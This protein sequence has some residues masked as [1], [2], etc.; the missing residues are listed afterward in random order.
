METD[1][2]GAIFSSSLGV[3]PSD[4]VSRP[5]EQCIGQIVVPGMILGISTS[6]MS[7]TWHFGTGLAQVPARSPSTNKVCVLVR[8]VRNVCDALYYASTL[9]YAVFSGTKLWCFW[10]PHCTNRIMFSPMYHLS[11]R[12]CAHQTKHGLPNRGVLQVSIMDNSCST[13]TGI[14]RPLFL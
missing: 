10:F 3:A 5:F 8:K 13:F 11:L 4:G 9:A 7:K 1:A 6:E 2:I 14:L 12:S